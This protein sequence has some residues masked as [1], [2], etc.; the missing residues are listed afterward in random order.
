[1]A[2]GVGLA[3]EQVGHRAAGSL[4]S[5]VGLQHGLYPKNP[6][7][8]DRGAVGQHH[9]D[10][11]LDLGHGFNQA[12]LPDRQ[13]HMRPVVALGFIA[14]RQAGKDDGHLGSLGGFNSG[15][16]QLL[17]ALVVPRVIQ[18]KALGIGQ[19]I[20]ELRQAS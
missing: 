9:H 3:I 2:A 1:M 5:Q 8:L 17:I 18:V 19:V 7:H 4:A 13:L 20:G 12:V 15:T 6:G 16:E 10:V 11:G 14:V